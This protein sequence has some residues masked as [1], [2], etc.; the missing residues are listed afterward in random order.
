MTQSE[1]LPQ[2]VKAVVDAI[3][4]SDEDAFVAAFAPDGY[5]DDW[6]RVLNGQDGVRSWS[7]TD[8]IGRN[9]AMTVLSASTDGDTTHLTFDW[10]SDRF[11]GQ[12]EAYIT[13]AGDR[14]TAFRIPAH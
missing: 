11:N 7:Q 4:N 3:N 1:A 2:P 6:G 5:V 9:A 12:S 8:A 13:V 14:V 10:S